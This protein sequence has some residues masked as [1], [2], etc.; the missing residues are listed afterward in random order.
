MAKKSAAP[1]D[2]GQA[3][4]QAKS[5][6]DTAQGFHGFAPDTTPNEAYTVAGVTAGMTAESERPDTETEPSEPEPEAAAPEP[7]AEG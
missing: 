2:S 7:E 6:I 4:V 1:T 5:D 3:E